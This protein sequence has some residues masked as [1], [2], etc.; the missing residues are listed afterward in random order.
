MLS[1]GVAAFIAHLAFWLLIAYGWFWDEIGP[2]SILVMV[3]LWVAGWL[4]LQH[5]PYG[6]TLFPS[7]VAALDI[8]L[9]WLVFKGDVRLK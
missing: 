1:P 8:A 4:G 9:V 6:A 3:V 2:T 5:V 7:Y